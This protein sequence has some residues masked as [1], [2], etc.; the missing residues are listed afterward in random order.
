MKIFAYVA[1]L[2]FPKDDKFAGVVSTS[3]IK[4]GELE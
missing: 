2:R 3:L 4:K 1:G